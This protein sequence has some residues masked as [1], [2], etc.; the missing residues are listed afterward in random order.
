MDSTTSST[1]EIENQ[2]ERELRRLEQIF[3]NENYMLER[4]LSQ[5]ENDSGKAN[6]NSRPPS[7]NQRQSR[8]NT[9]KIVSDPDPKDYSEYEIA[10]AEGERE[11]LNDQLQI[12]ISR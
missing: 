11:K 5:S 6:S 10:R 8:K 12:M 4:S 9:Q 1:D 7:F 2:L 3:D